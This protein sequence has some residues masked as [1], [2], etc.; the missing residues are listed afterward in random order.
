MAHEDLT[1][2][3][4]GDV[5]GIGFQA[6][7]IH[8]DVHV[9]YT[10]LAASST[11][12]PRCTP[13][14][15]WGATTDLPA[16]VQ[17]LL[18][19]Q[20][21]CA[22]L[23]PYQLP[24]ARKPSL[25]TV[26]VRQD[27]G[28][29][30]EDAQPE[31]RPAPTLDEHGQLVDIP[32][33][34]VARVAVRPPS[35]PMRAALDTDDHLVITGGP[36]QGKS[37]LTLRLTAD[38]VRQWTTKSP[39]DAPL[40]EPVLPL[41][42]PARVLAEHLGPS[43][44][45]S[46]ANS[47]A[48]EYGHLL[49]D[50]LDPTLFASHVVG[51]RWLLLIDALDEVADTHTRAKIVHT[52]SAWAKKSTYR[53]LLTTRPTESGAL[54]AFQR[55]ACRYELQ[56][57][58][59]I[60]LHLFATHWFDEEGEDCA[61]RFLQQ[62]REAHLFE[63]VEV[64]LLATIAAIVF[65]QHARDPLP[66]NQYELYEVYLDHIRKPD[67]TPVVFER[68]R[69]PLIEY[70]GRT[71][72]ETDT[73]LTAA[74]HAWTQ[75]HPEVGSADD[76]IAHLKAC[77]LFVQRGRELTFLH[78]SFAEHVAA[79]AKARELPPE[80]DPQESAFADLLHQAQ[81]LETGRF[82]RAVLLHHTRLHP[83]EANRLLRW[84][85]DGKAEQHLLA[86]RLLA[87]HM[88][89][90]ASV[91]DE[92]LT[93]VRGWAATT[94]Y[95][96]RAILG[97]ASRA[98]QHPGLGSWLVELTQDELAPFESRAEAAT[99]L[100]V[101]LRDTYASEAI[102]LLRSAVDNESAPVQHR[103]IAAEALAHS[104]S[105]ER[106]AGERGL[107]SVLRDSFA[108]G[109]SCRTAGVVL[110]AFGGAAR[111][112]ALAELNRLLS[113]GD[114]PDPDLVNVATALVEIGA[115][116]HERCADSFLA[117]VRD[118]VHNT[119]GKRDAALGL[120]A[121]GEQEAAAEAIMEVG[122]DRLRTAGHQ[123]YA[124]G[125]LALLG[126]RMRAAAGD[127]LVARL[128]AFDTAFFGQKMY[129]SALVRLGHRDLAIELMRRL[130]AD[131]ST[132]W[133][134]VVMM[135]T[136]LGEL[137]PAFHDEAAIHL[138]RA[139]RY[140]RNTYYEFTAPLRELA[141]LAEP[142]RRRAT[143]L[144]RGALTDRSLD[145]QIRC[146]VANELIRCAPQFH[147]VAVEH[148]VLIASSEHAPDVRAMAWAKLHR[149]GPALAERAQTELLALARDHEAL[150]ELGIVF[151][152][153][154]AADRRSAA[155]VLTTL[156][157]DPQRS[158]RTRLNATQGLI[159][160]GK[161]FH[162]V[163]LAGAVD[164]LHAGLVND[165]MRLAQ[166][167]TSTG[168]GVR[169]DLATVLGDLLP[170]QGLNPQ[171]RMRVVKAIDVLG[172]KA[173]LAVVR[174]LA[175]DESV[176]LDV[177]A[178]AAVKVASYDPGQLDVAS[179]VVFAAA[180]MM[181]FQRWKQLAGYLAQLGVD[182]HARLRRI[183]ASPDAGRY[184]T[185][186]AA[187][188]VEVEAL[189]ACSEDQYSDFKFRLYAY[190]L[191]AIRGDYA[192]ESYLTAILN[193]PD[194]PIA[195][196]CSAVVE[197]AER[198]LTMQDQASATVWR[199]VESWHL[200]IAER[201]DAIKALI[202]LVPQGPRLAGLIV[203]L[204]HHP[205]RSDK[206][207]ASLV[208]HLPRAERTLV[209]R[210]LL[211][212]QSIAVEHRMPKVDHWGDA[213]L[214]TEA[215]ATAREV[216]RSPEYSAVDR[217]EALVALA[218]YS[219]PQATEALSLLVAQ[220]SAEDLKEAAKLGA[221]EE[222]HDRL[223]TIVSDEDRPIRERRAAALVIGEIEHE[224]SVREFLRNDVRASWRDRVDELK[225]VK[226]FDELRAIRDDSTLPPHYRRRAAVFLL[227]RSI[228][229][230]VASAKVFAS[231]ATDTSAH[232]AL[233]WWAADDLS[234]LGARGRAEALPLLNA[235]VRDKSLP[236]IVRSD[237]ADAIG[238]KWPTKREEV[239]ELLRG[240]LPLAKP[241]QRIQVLRD[242]GAIR[243]QEG[244]DGLNAMAAD[245]NMGPVVRLWAAIRMFEL[246]RDMKERAAVVAREIAFDDAMPAHVRRRAAQR[247]ARW[248]EVCRED[249]RQLLYT[250][251]LPC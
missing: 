82:A 215:E 213:P 201:V 81:P 68:H 149:L 60:A 76:L 222:V 135:T 168:R 146:E 14:A 189:R 124:L 29:G 111:D 67:T 99:A 214:C 22:D 91:L 198:D 240:L 244:V 86:A 205:E 79:T 164:L 15:D 129:V 101:R 185:V 47:A 48:A 142:H 92:F 104:G 241:L 107:R 6:D 200:R 53:V 191:R 10:P 162:R 72:L 128:D 167:F 25:G 17:D 65:E 40:A 197:L 196:R 88:L 34:P 232:P 245:T 134:D 43:F 115:E 225:F 13:P 175:C 250:L 8:G 119:A 125:T 209:E 155:E 5:H 211:A 11:T 114:T 130:L 12:Q 94:Q 69:V 170:R 73:S 186:E 71:R 127:M 161:A 3:S 236:V 42:I 80:F 227:Y 30:V 20:E 249:A 216:L 62:I 9:T 188:F 87:Q 143:A 180:P 93:V 246:S 113:D 154:G 218:G 193:D 21:Q 90:S 152:A 50:P 239:L 26:Y 102:A 181:A 31:H 133:L 19:A 100:A 229:D 89:T 144:L 70:L 136:A 45:H 187:F 207:A 172:H 120:V 228:D 171:N 242:I 178:E 132:S 39:E 237:V 56:P 23:L 159:M 212:D 105:N 231:I 64:P 166:Y 177:R 141:N 173:P 234:D 230:R 150:S 35:K 18:W 95:P 24:G 137:G 190:R 52:L 74:V 169:A 118:P 160:L 16:V 192:S 148:L 206:A 49:A 103:L 126:P 158:L 44:S 98:S 226:A 219:L 174:D 121:L 28:S 179:D 208:V 123:S 243:V 204:V 247:L 54:A 4:M 108:S 183:A 32:P 223:H 165:P 184:T 58:D 176:D 84:L 139:H 224:P 202:G 57:F 37:T 122:C 78:H 109:H 36:G 157:K 131:P 97:Q 117:V 77:G 182:V 85:H 116:F 195:D 63:L 106:E 59:E 1:A 221:W 83:A 61:N 248:S 235:M 140:S 7:T 27:V 217:R 251:R 55:V 66:G 51:C 38:I 2:N 203:A 138:Q 147:A 194:Q 33:T 163:A 238:K 75:E 153:A 233:R 210:L 110:A 151:A 156:L 220:G 145:P 199:F 41:R 46:L 112:F 96:A